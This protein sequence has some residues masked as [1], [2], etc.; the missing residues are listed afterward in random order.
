[1]VIELSKCM[2]IRSKIDLRP[3]FEILQNLT[4]FGG[5]YYLIDYIYH[6]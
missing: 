1:M 5:P 4:H 2:L 3:G 6:N